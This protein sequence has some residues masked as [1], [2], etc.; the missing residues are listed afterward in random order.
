MCLSFL[1]KP[2]QAIDKDRSLL[3]ELRQIGITSQ[4]GREK[5]W[6]DGIRT[7]LLQLLVE[8]Q[9]HRILHVIVTGELCWIQFSG[10]T[11]QPNAL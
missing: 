4:K 8:V 2:P 3:Y 1:F 9:D 7:P 6:N 5:V 11:S 10:Q